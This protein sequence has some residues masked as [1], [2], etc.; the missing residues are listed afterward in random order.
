MNIEILDI[1]KLPIVKSWPAVAKAMAG[2]HSKKINKEVIKKAL[3]MMPTKE[4]E[5]FFIAK[6]KKKL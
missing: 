3:R 4:I 6:I 1:K 5:G 2:K